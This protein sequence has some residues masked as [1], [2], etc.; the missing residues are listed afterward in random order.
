MSQRP[1]LHTQ[2]EK[3]NNTVRNVI[4]ILTAL[5]LVFTG[6][7][8]FVSGLATQ[9]QVN[10]LRKFVVDENIKQQLDIDTLKALNP[11]HSAELGQV[12]AA[13]I[14]HLEIYAGEL[15]AERGNRSTAA[16]RASRARAKFRK[17]IAEGQTIDQALYGS[18]DS[19]WPFDDE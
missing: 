12:K 17:A 4:G 8:N 7:H 14:Q 6:V 5:G 15:A 3:A 13:V 10:S 2:A 16:K 18:Q 9:D 19:Y 1:S 11:K